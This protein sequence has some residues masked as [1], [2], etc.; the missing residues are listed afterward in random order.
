M[1]WLPAHRQ[2][3]NDLDERVVQA[4]MFVSDNPAANMTDSIAGSGRVKVDI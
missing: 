3:M 1:F 2:L 4:V